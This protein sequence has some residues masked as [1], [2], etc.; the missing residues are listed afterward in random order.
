M[1]AFRSHPDR[2]GFTLIELLVVIAVMGLLMAILLPALSM[3]REAAS[4][5]D[6]QNRL[7]QMG[8]ASIAYQSSNGYFP[9]GRAWPDVFLANGDRALAPPVTNYEGVRS[10]SGH[11]TNLY[12]VHVALL[13][14]LEM[15]GVA[16][17]MNFDVTSPI[18]LTN[19]PNATA[20]TM[21][22][23]AFI[24]PSD[25]VGRTTVGENNY[26]YNFG[27]DTPYSGWRSVRGLSSDTQGIPN[28]ITKKSVPLAP[29]QY[30]H[31]RS[32][33]GNGAFTIRRGLTGNDFTDGLANTVFF[34]E[35]D[36]GTADGTP[37]GERLPDR[38]VIV[39][40]PNGED[41]DNRE[42]PVPPS[43][44]YTAC[45]NYPAR[46]DQFN[47]FS[48]GRFEIGSNY[49][50]G[51]PFA[52]Y[53]STMYNHVAPPNWKGFDCG[54]SSSIPDVPGEHAIITAR[55]SHPGIVNVCFGDGHVEAISDSIDTEIWRAMG[56]RN[57]GESVRSIE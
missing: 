20:Y 32:I 12:S 41:M 45:E 14:Y 33:Q 2:S 26:R 30:F 22:A 50:N 39:S 8:V 35:R 11:R 1:K 3:V 9:V 55:S 37:A 42:I 19:N 15:Q 54:N 48:A 5:L 4:R 31:G 21:A 51:W 25:R 44:L 16:D 29:D 56:T 18:R 57:G 23:G 49:A 34:S 10:E 27:G 40:R 47:F 53:T 36:K 46:R 13:S 28:P 6:C 17:L 43:E 38:T 52:A 7:K 24:C